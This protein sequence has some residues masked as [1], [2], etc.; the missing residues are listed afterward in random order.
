MS[1]KYNEILDHLMDD[2]GGPENVGFIT[3]CVTRLRFNVKD[4]GLVQDKEIEKLSGVIAQ[5]WVGDQYQ[6]VIGNDVGTVYQMLLKKYPALSNSGTKNVS[7]NNEPKKKKIS[8]NRFFDMIAG[9]VSPLIPVLIGA[10][11]LK[12]VMILLTISGLLSDQSSTYYIL[13][14]VSDAGFYFLPIF[15]GVY[16]AKR[17][18]TNVPLAMLLCASLLHPNF[19]SAVNEGMGLTF[20]GIPVY[21]ITYSSM[22]IPPILIVFVMSFVEK[23]I[24]KHMWAAVRTFM[25]PLLTLLIM[26]PL[27]LCLL[28]PAGAF[29]GNYFTAAILWLYNHVRII[30]MPLLVA[31]MPLIVMTGMHMAINTTVFQFFTTM[32]YD[33]F[34]VAAFILANMNQGAAC[35][36]VFLKA[37]KENV[38]SVALSSAITVIVGGVSEPGMY[39]VTLKYKTPMY[40]AII[41][42]LAG[43]IVA[44]VFPTVCYSLGGVSLLALPTFIGGG[45]MASLYTMIAS[46]II[47]MVVTFIATLFLYKEEKE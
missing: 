44:G 20:I 36:A 42:G 40:G 7:A 33:P 26:T 14:F 43:G 28:A 39:G 21:G 35:L 8:I 45:T 3:H 47:G 27:S 6:V 31:F 11:M 15:I 17:F 29:I 5:Q 25:V 1:K 9:C 46:I 34:I 18:Q 2:L 22:I 12:V 19:A 24:S 30:A 10:G 38:K 32:K 16:S 13:N 4:R 23:F 41:G 37:K